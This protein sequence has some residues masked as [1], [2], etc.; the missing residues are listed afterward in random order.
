MSI[1]KKDLKTTSLRFL[2]VVGILNSFYLSLF[3]PPIARYFAFGFIPLV[4]VN[5][6]YLKIRSRYE[7]IFSYL[8]YSL[9]F[10]YP[11]I[12]VNFSPSVPDG[13]YTGPLKFL[14]LQILQLFV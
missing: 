5:L 3:H 7:P 14:W 13:L 8:T 12:W 9:F 10:F 2:F 11:V 4:L 1:V 6:L